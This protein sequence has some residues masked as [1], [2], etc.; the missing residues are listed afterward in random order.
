M[1]VITHDSAALSGFD[2]VLRLER[3]ALAEEL[4]F[5]AS[6]AQ[7]AVGVTAGSSRGAGRPA[8]A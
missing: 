8:A 6:V 4:A 5:P 7:T 3:G 1:L 2:R